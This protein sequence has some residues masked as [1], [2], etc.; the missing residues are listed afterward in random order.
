MLIAK[1]EP[2]LEA[3]E[4]LSLQ[5]QVPMVHVSE[6]L[7]DY[8]QALVEFSRTEGRFNGGLSPRA[9]L[10]L[11]HSAQAYAMVDGR[12]Q[13]V[14]EDVQAVLA[15]VA[16]HRLR[17]MGDTS[18]DAGAEIAEQLIQSVAIP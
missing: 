5:Q 7:L 11:L 16:I 15:A 13:V 8:L 1:L 14:P 6:A 3:K 18:S 12:Q 4:L 17:P 9:S 2:C 10:A